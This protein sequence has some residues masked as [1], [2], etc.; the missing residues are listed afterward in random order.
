MTCLETSVHELQQLLEDGIS[1]KLY[2]GAQLVVSGRDENLLSLAVGKTRSQVDVY[3]AQYRPQAVKPDTLFDVASLTKPL[4]TAALVMKSIDEHH[5]SLGQK[6]ISIGGFQ[7]PSWIL[8]NTIE[9]LLS[10]QTQLPAWYDFHGEEPRCEEHE[11]SKKFFEIE[12]LRLSPRDDKSTWCYSDLGYIWLGILLESIY[13]QNLDL[14]FTRQISKP[15]GLDKSMMFNPLHHVSSLNIAA[16]SLFHHSYLLGHPDDANARVLTHI[17]GHAGLFSSAEAISSYVRRLLSHRFPCN[18]NTI[19]AFLNY[20]HPGTP[21]ALGWDR[22]TSDDSLS[23][24]KPGENV[25][26]HLGFTGCSVWIDLD[27]GRSVTLLTNR[28]HVNSEP[29]SLSDLRRAVYKICWNL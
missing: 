16:T 19:D 14:L 25:I 22:P 17:A 2:S 20:R 6:L 10:H 1:Q 5:L 4:A 24:R 23:G 18:A 13:G 27:T 3:D 15:I 12:S 11:S 28:P 7:F 29:K 8:G 9:D 21:F 26:G